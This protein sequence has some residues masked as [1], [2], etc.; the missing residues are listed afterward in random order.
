MELRLTTHSPL[1]TVLTDTSGRSLYRISSPYAC[2]NRITTV[3][4]I[5]DVTE[6]ISKDKEGDGD[7]D[8]DLD[9]QT[10]V[11]GRSTDEEHDI[12]RLRWKLLSSSVLE[13]GG[14]ERETS[15]FIPGKG[16]CWRYR[17]FTASDGRSYKWSIGFTEP[18][19]LF[20]PSCTHFGG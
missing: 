7:K 1:N 10:I 6:Y 20:F 3:S 5:S 17:V 8:K 12:A 2:H 9:G 4:K 19:V 15:D 11:A 13:F 14:F 16:F 18:K